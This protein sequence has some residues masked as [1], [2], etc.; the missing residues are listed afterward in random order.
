MDRV[1]FLDRDGVINKYPGDRNYVN[2]WKEFKF[3]PGSIGAIKMLNASGFRIF[4]VSNQAGVA[5]GLYS[6]EDLEYI[7][8]KMN[9]ALKKEGAY[10]SGI[11]Y[12]I[13]HFLH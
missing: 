3:I 2:N 1:I 5:K 9:A 6:F 8:K 7:N 13:H 11:Y 12:C 4:V 10:L